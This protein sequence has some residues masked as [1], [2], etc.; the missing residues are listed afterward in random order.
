MTNKARV[1]SSSALSPP[2]QEVL[3]QSAADTQQQLAVDLN[4]E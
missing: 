2:G 3:K 4:T 1:N